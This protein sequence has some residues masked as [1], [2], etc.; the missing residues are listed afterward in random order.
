MRVTTAPGPASC[1]RTGGVDPGTVLS[2]NSVQ[3]I[4]R[5]FLI[6]TAWL[7]WNVPFAPA[8]QGLDFSFDS[9][10]RFNAD[11]NG[12]AL[13]MKGEVAEGDL[14]RLLRFLREHPR[15]FV[16]HGGRVVFVV[17][18]G[19]IVEAT[20]IGHFLRDAL[21]EAWLPDASRTRCVS[22][23]FFMFVN[24]VSRVAVA[25]SVGVHRPYFDA[26]RLAGADPEPA[27]RRYESLL[28]E[29]RVALDE[30]L[31]PRDLTEKM[32]AT[33]W[34]ETYWFS[35]GDLD[36]LGETQAWFEDFSAA[37]CGVEPR[38]KQ[39]LESAIAAGF[40][41]EAQAL[42]TEFEGATKCVAELRKRQRQQV[43]ERLPIDP[44]K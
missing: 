39:R 3:T 16:E 31:V 41:A 35:R 24:A 5:S 23:C 15:D 28:R 30:L 8:Q 43:I 29:V 37:K 44:G 25:E 22:A 7:C 32:L 33:P 17:D 6:A 21:I 19:D 26:K 11:A 27:R 20:R 1:S 38:L 18:G 9:V 36:R 13:W 42:Q 34:N 4:L 12:K 40:E 2:G 14:D 10:A